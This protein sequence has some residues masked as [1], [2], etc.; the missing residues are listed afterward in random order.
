[1]PKTAAVPSPAAPA[2]LTSVWIALAIVYVVWGS[3]YLAIRYGVEVA[4]P[5]LFASARFAVAS[6]AMLAY[7]WARGLSFP[8]TRREWQVIATTGA[9]LLAGANGLVTWSEQ[10]VASNQAALI[11]ATSALW[12]AWIGTWGQRGEGLSKLTWAGLLLGFAGVAVLVSDG[13]VSRAAPTGAY[14]ALM[15][16]PILW[17]GGSVYA[18]RNPVACSPVVT[19]ALQMFT[20]SVLMAFIGLAL[21]EPAEWRWNAQAWYALAYLAVFGSI[22]G[23]GAYFYLVHNTTPWYDSLP[24]LSTWRQPS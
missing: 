7:A 1:M 20:A 5:Y 2:S 10:W 11:V 21:G 14:V 19:A 24:S 4:P 12:M 8:S 16:S 23:Y 22:I 13:L 17:A 3:T 9:L 15:I 18:R 6:L